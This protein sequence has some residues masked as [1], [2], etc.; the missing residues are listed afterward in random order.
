MNEKE[1]KRLRE[2]ALTDQLDAIHDEAI[3]AAEVNPLSEAV[4]YKLAE[5]AF[6]ELAVI[7][8]TLDVLL[9][10]GFKLE[11]QEEIRKAL[12]DLAVALKNGV[13]GN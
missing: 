9:V 8:A 1:V 11:K 10:N 12:K 7:R 13:G 5:D 6:A 2:V 4:Y 3:H